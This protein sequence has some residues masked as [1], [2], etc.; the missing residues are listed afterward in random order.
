MNRKQVSNN[1]V[2]WENTTKIFL[3]TISPKKRK[4]K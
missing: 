3:R 4:R 1:F 2:G